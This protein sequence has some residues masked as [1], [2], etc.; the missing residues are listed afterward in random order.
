[1]SV[2]VNVRAPSPAG[3][4]FRCAWKQ[5]NDQSGK[6]KRNPRPIKRRKFEGKSYK[7]PRNQ[8]RNSEKEREDGAF[9]SPVFIGTPANPSLLTPIFA[10]DSEDS[11]VFTDFFNIPY[12]IAVIRSSS[13]SRR[14]RSHRVLF[15][16]YFKMEKSTLRGVTVTLILCNVFNKGATCDTCFFEVK[17]RKTYVES[18][19][20]CQSKYYNGSI[21]PVPDED[22]FTWLQRE[23]DKY[24]H[25]GEKIWAGFTYDGETL[26][27]SDGS[28]KTSDGY[29]LWNPDFPKSVQLAGT[30]GCVNSDR[31]VQQ[32]ECRSN[33]TALKFVCQKQLSSSGGCE[34][35]KNYWRYE[36][37]CLKLHNVKKSINDAEKSCEK[38][39]SIVSPITDYTILYMVLTEI[40][41]YNFS[42]GIWIGL[43]KIDGQWMNSDGTP[44]EQVSF[45][46]EGEP[47]QNDCAVFSLRQGYK[48]ISVSCDIETYFLCRGDGVGM[49]DF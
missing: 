17:K 1:M 49:N 47:K 37:H 29:K 5:K 46:A 40:H 11:F 3:L 36:S 30:C 39:N 6:G 32:I 43:H 23:I 13:S 4:G 41:V 21:A 28:T 25:L 26:T 35:D 9:N 2:A 33:E 24:R 18:E 19:Q 15:Y 22:T 7:N 14:S 16:C 48:F 42:H 45:W 27:F 8:G 31:T 10:T 44:F 12:P 34:E 38:E 20:I